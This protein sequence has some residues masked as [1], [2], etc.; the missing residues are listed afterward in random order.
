[1]LHHALCKSGCDNYAFRLRKKQCKL[2]MCDCGP[3]DNATLLDDTNKWRFFWPSV[4]VHMVLPIIWS[5]QKLWSFNRPSSNLTFV[6]RIPK[7]TQMGF[8]P[9]TFVPVQNE[10]KTNI[11]RTEWSCFLYYKLKEHVSFPLCLPR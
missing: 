5:I 7:L 2:V 11:K 4:C 1:M 3:T 9:E 8:G 10:T 6:S